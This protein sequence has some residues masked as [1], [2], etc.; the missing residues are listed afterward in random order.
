MTCHYE[1]A[2]F[3]TG[4]EMIQ[5]YF[6]VSMFRSCFDCQWVLRLHNYVSVFL[7][8]LG[9]LWSVVIYVYIYIYY[10]HLTHTHTH[11]YLYI[12]IVI[13]FLQVWRMLYYYIVSR[14]SIN[15][16]AQNEEEH[17]FLHLAVRRVPEG[18]RSG[19]YCSICSDSKE[20]DLRFPD[21]I[22]VLKILSDRYERG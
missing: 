18:R 10:I 7:D 21:S 13:G 6:L 11:I 2:I 8:V 12:Y 22:R 9:I 17:T 15:A 5:A 20:S 3:A 1:L 19:K 16:H 4:P 14:Q